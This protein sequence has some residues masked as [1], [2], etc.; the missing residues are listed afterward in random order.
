MYKAKKLLSLLVERLWCV[1]NQSLQKQNFLC[2]Q[3]SFTKHWNILI[4]FFYQLKFF[5][6]TVSKKRVKSLFLLKFSA[7]KT[8][9]SL[10]ANLYRS[11]QFQGR[12]HHQYQPGHISSDLWREVC[13]T[14]IIFIN[15]FLLVGSVSTVQYQG[16]SMCMKDILLLLYHK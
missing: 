4:W 6:G 9:K 1:E 8:L 16:I 14:V 13:R 10:F 12:V 5:Q 3:F 2:L 15:I 7:Y 11:A